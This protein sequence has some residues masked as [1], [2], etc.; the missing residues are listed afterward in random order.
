M[1]LFQ[2]RYQQAVKFLCSL[3]PKKGSLKILSSI[4]V[5]QKKESITYEATDLDTFLR[6]RLPLWGNIEGDYV[7]DAKQLM[8]APKMISTK[9]SADRISFG[10]LSVPAQDIKEFPSLETRFF[11]NPVWE[12][13]CFSKKEFVEIGKR[14]CNYASALELSRGVLEGVCFRN[15]YFYAT[16]GNYLLKAKIG[17][18]AKKG[19]E[20]IM[21][22]TFFKLLSNEFVLDDEIDLSVFR[23]DKEQGYIVARGMS[24]ELVSKL[25]SD[26]YPVVERVL[27]KE[28]PYSYTIERMPFLEAVTKAVMYANK[29]SHLTEL[30]PNGKGLAIKVVDKEGGIEF[31]ENIE[32]KQLSKKKWTGCSFNAKSMSVILSDAPGGI[33]TFKAGE[34]KLSALTIEPESDPRLFFLLMPLRTLEEDGKDP[35]KDDAKKGN[36]TAPKEPEKE[37]ASEPVK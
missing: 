4:K 26:E 30:V 14:A 11:T 33:V 9:I 34:N 20:F 10:N 3:I 27:P 1:P 5:S 35:S 29:K 12:Q 31:S 25:I 15:G 16:N 37:K 32:A 23:A 17:L 21:P 19:F 6:V 28:M 13:S 18:K 22:R 7:V 2:N 24:F 36:E 8:K